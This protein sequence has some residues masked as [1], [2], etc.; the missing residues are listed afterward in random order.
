MYNIRPPATRSPSDNVTVILKVVVAVGLVVAAVDGYQAITGRR[1][2]KRP[3]RR[4]DRQMRV[5]SAIAA[6]VLSAMCVGLIALN[7][8]ISK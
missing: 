1:V 7:I 5:Q 2:S 3:S 6:I 4:T 8:A